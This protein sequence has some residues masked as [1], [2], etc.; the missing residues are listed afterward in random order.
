MCASTFYLK[1][2]MVHIIYQMN[3]SLGA[4]KSQVQIPFFLV[5]FWFNS[6]LL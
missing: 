6:D 3:T 1:S 5:I 4:K 2:T